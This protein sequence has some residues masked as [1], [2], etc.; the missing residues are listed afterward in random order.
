MRRLLFGL[1]FL[2]IGALAD[3]V[4]AHDSAERLRI[5]AKAARL[6]GDDGK[7]RLVIDLSAPVKAEVFVLANP[8]RVV[9]DLPGVSFPENET[10]QSASRGLV[11]AY[12]FG[13]IAQGRARVVIEVNR[14]VTVGEPQI[15]SAAEGQP[16]RL[17]LEFSPAS[18]DEFRSAPAF[19]RGK[20]ASKQNVT[21]VATAETIRDA[22]PL[23]MLDPG[24]GGIDVGA[25]ALTGEQEKDIV[26][27]FAQMLRAH[28][29]K[30]GRY[31][32]MMTRE[33][34][35]FISLGER[36]EMARKQGAALFISIHADSISDPFNV[37]GATIYTL[38]DRASDR[39]A[40]KLAEKE[41]RSDM[42]AGFDLSEEPNEVADIL[43]ELTH[44][45]TRV[46]SLRFARILMRVIKPSVRL[47]KNPMR[48]A[49]FRVLK[50]HDVPS[51]LLELGYI[52][53][54]KDLKLLTSETWRA[55]VANDMVSAVDRFFGERTA[56]TTGSAV[57]LR[58]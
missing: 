47:N 54:P 20:V 6:G 27:A 4:L 25:Q 22:R 19:V 48:A 1:M 28:L 37:S 7:T 55:K 17:V 5:E 42:I 13:Q 18:E 11:T 14:P 21:E 49:S 35:H 41:N 3:P 39:E 51:I 23:I 45:E 31:Q 56:E 8:Y 44:R 15:I 33:D 30:S 26:L 29:Q 36:V 9:L 52:S 34:D 16:A 50:A 57:L 24:H 58:K 53:N 32:V 46:F 38:S 40:A 2:T 12:R 43:I 10:P